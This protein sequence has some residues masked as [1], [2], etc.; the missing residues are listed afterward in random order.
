MI[1]SSGKNDPLLYFMAHSREHD[2]EQATRGERS[3]YGLRL[4]SELASDFSIGK[5]HAPCASMGQPH[6]DQREERRPP[7]PNIQSSPVIGVFRFLN[8]SKCS[9]QRTPQ[10]EVT[11]D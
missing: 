9:A 11:K 1:T 2:P 7:L 5:H 10:L 8:Y 3:I 6:H 4:E